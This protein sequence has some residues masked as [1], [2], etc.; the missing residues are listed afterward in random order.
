MDV[1][2]LN[3]RPFLNVA[4][5]GFDAAV[6][7]SFQERGRRGARRGFLGYL[8]ISLARLRAYVPPAVELE[9]PAGTRHELRPFALTFANG[10]QYGS[11]AVINPGARLDDGVL[12]A[13][14]FAASTLPR[15]FAAVP[16][17]FLGGI[18]RLPEYRRF[19]TPCATVTAA[20]PLPVHL[21]GDPGP[22]AARIEVRL[23]PGAL[24]VLVPQ[25]TLV[26][27]A[28][29]IGLVAG[30]RQVATASAC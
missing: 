9:L 4:G 18:E 17:L 29:P 1:G 13:V 15:T 5:L 25:A 2:F 10:P 28:A 7:Q 30:A 6:S 21:D 27:T 24:L 19:A 22:A 11:G 26:A 20:E 8:R 16:R 14:S 3:E 23:Q 12:E